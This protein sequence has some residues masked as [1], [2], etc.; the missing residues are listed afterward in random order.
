MTYSPEPWVADICRPLTSDSPAGTDPRYLD[1]FLFIKE[2]LDKLQGTDY[3]EVTKLC[4][5]LLSVTSKDLRLAGYHLLS[6]TYVDGPGGLLDALRCYRGLVENLWA[7]CFPRHENAR[8][9]ALGLLN[10]PRLVSFVELHEEKAETALLQNLQ[11]ETAAINHLLTE[12]LGDEVPRLS[13]LAG[14]LDKRLKQ[15]PPE[16]PAA[17]PVSRPAASEE[18]SGRPTSA[19]TTATLSLA[20]EHDLTTVTRQLHT[21]LLEG[22]EWLRALGFSRALR[23]GNLGVPPDEN[24]LTRI[25]PPRPSGWAELQ[26]KLTAGSG[27]EALCCCEK[28]FFEP[29]FHLYF[30]LQWQAA[31]AADQ[32]GRA[33][34]SLFIRN[35]L[36]D[37]LER[38]PQ[39]TELSFADGTPF[40]GTACQT[41]M[42]TWQEVPARAHTCHENDTEEAIRNE[43]LAE[44]LPL[45]RNKKL[46]EA[47]QCLRSLPM[48]TEKQRMHKKMAEAQLCL[49]AGK[50]TIAQ[51]L[52]EE[53][54]S[55]LLEE[56]LSTWE[57]ELTVEVLRQHTAL[58]QGKLKGA[59]KEL[60]S[61]LTEQIEHL[62]K[63][64]CR[65]D[66]GAA[67][68]FV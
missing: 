68:G 63:L 18:P 9:A 50:A 17:A 32:M 64:A 48:G 11:E 25:P 22:G 24:G 6:T 43:V 15:R 20:S 30:D 23:W 16:A 62:Q 61:R 52:F 47:L 31:S 42:Q 55:R 57:P 3:P 14:W 29:G 41:W 49:A 26:Q 5:K 12:H 56:P 8:V 7:D 27:A 44:A 53:M 10:N 46:A 21:R 67:A 28:L 37:L 33:D 45:A 19:P 36:G 4:R 66:V 2:E 60:K 13:S 38:H 65:I 1:E 54:E 35:S 40:T 58:L 39:L 51:V 34:I 59:E